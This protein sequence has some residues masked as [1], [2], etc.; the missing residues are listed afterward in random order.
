MIALIVNTRTKEVRHVEMIEWHA[1]HYPNTITLEH[2]ADRLIKL[3]AA[4]YPKAYKFFV[5]PEKHINIM[6][7]NTT[8]C[9]FEV[10]LI[11]ALKDYDDDF[12]C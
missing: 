10:K 1:G 7:G 8:K 5:I 3:I 12:L 2:V 9:I 4:T 11:E 6:A